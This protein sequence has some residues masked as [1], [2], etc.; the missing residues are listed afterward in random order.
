MTGLYFIRLTH[1]AFDLPVGHLIYIGEGQDVEARASD[2]VTG[3]NPA[4]F[5]RSIGL[6]I[7]VKVRAR[8]GKKRKGYN[9][10]FE[11]PQ[12]V[13]DWLRDNV[14]VKTQRFEGTDK[15]RKAEEKAL[16]KKHRPP[17]NI[18]HNQEWCHPDLIAL[19]KEAHR[20]AA[21]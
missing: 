11:Q 3:A 12:L 15:E 7:G 19:R 2:E 21:R 17:I 20:I 18:E 13:I 10:K 1:P 6:L 8:S 14:T 16:I 5:F 4:T 9:F